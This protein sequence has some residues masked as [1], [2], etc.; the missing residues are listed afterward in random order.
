VDSCFQTPHSPQPII[1]RVVPAQS[2]W[3]PIS[4]D[5]RTLNCLNP[6]STHAPS[7]CSSSKSNPVCQHPH[8]VRESM[9]TDALQELCFPADFSLSKIV[10]CYSASSTTQSSPDGGF[11][12]VSPG[13]DVTASNEAHQ[14]RLVELHTTLDIV[15]TKVMRSTVSR[16]GRDLQ[17]W[18]DTHD[19][20]QGI[21][22]VTGAVPILSDSR[23]LLV[24]AG[25]KAEWIFPKGGWESDE[26]LEESA[27]REAFEEAGCSG[28][29]GPP[30]ESILYK[31]SKTPKP[32]LETEVKFAM[33]VDGRESPYFGLRNSTPSQR[34]PLCSAAKSSTTS[35]GS[36][37][38]LSTLEIDSCASSSNIHNMLSP[39]P[40]TNS[41]PRDYTHVRMVL[42]PLYVREVKDCWPESGR[43]RKALQ[44]D[45][46]IAAL[47][48]RPELQSI[49]Q[50][51]KDKNLHLTAARCPPAH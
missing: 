16:E 1:P 5:Q 21:R 11:H 6:M 43:L 17:R 29:L 35:R 13:S 34:P 32:R 50:D 44:I 23:I 37:T 25:K 22:L 3:Q 40:P 41:S 24:S 19:D 4:S 8:M 14:A 26:Y 18:E 15:T 30:L 42:F 48:S 7:T 28:V 39:D 46:A 9:S 20:S 36:E 33:E 49:L 10:D 2:P 27:I 38:S 12:P 31:R 45:D 47:A 51:I